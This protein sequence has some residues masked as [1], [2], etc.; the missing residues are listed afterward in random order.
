MHPSPSPSLRATAR[1]AAAEKQVFISFARGLSMVSIVLYHLLINAHLPPLLARANQIGGAGIYVFL[2]ASSYGLYF[3]RPT[4]WSTFYFKRFQKVLVPYYV[5]IT[6]IFLVNHFI[7]LYPAGW[8][9]YL[10]HVL[11]YKMFFP[12]Y[13]ESFGP[14]FWFI[15]TI[16]QFYLLW[17]ALLAVSRQLSAPALLGGALLISLLYSGLLLR[18]GVQHE[19]IWCSSAIQYLWLFALGLVT[20]REQWL[21]RLLQLGAVRFGL[22]MG[23]GLGAAVLLSRFA[24]EQ[25]NV[26]ND[27]FMFL[28]YFSGCVL[29]FL[30]GQRLPALTRAIL[31][32]ESFSFSLYLTH[33]FL[34]SF[35]LKAVSQLEISLFEVPVVAAICVAGALL[36]DKLVPL[37]TNLRLWQRQPAV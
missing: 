1:P 16:V 5:A 36:F 20:A 25:G 21:P 13:M 22:L 32:L 6:L 17:P 14:H 11:L 31:W 30:L 27:Y 3:S 9:E 26:L 24:G 8:P 7:V 4:S 19:R 18:L 34:F 35:Y 10:S 33:L 29:L 12:Q 23:L 15:S 37:L 2:F 28:A